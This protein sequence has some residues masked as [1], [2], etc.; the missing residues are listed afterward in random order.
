MTS[1]VKGS[2]S[3]HRQAGWTKRERSRFRILSATYDSVS[4]DSKT[5][6]LSVLA[7]HAGLGKATAYA[8]F[9]DPEEATYLL[10]QFG[11]LPLVSSPDGRQKHN[12]DWADLGDLTRVSEFVHTR[13]PGEVKPSSLIASLTRTIDRASRSGRHV[14]ET[15]SRIVLTEAL[16]EFDRG[17]EAIMQLAEA[18][19]SLE[20]YSSDTSLGAVAYI[21]LARSLGTFAA[22]YDVD[23]DEDPTRRFI[24]FLDQAAHWSAAVSRYDVTAIAAAEM[25]A[26]RW[27]F[28]SQPSD[29]ALDRS[30][31]RRHIQRA[32]VGES[33][34]PTGAHPLRLLVSLTKPTTVQQTRL[35]QF[36]VD[37]G[38]S[39][40]NRLLALECGSELPDS[41]KTDLLKAPNDSISVTCGRY[42]QTPRLSDRIRSHVREHGRAQAGE[43]VALEDLVSRIRVEIA[44]LQLGATLEPVEKNMLLEALLALTGLLE[45]GSISE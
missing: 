44:R 15:L 43:D 9:D 2:A 45:D 24:E 4:L 26:T 22:L 11:F 29:V 12:E 42:H 13:A 28:G 35:V 19:A 40:W 33:V 27:Y 18:Q 1:V 5:P 31:A 8:L 39:R 3:S 25:L 7:D 21:R 41:L 34:A 17:P 6:S 32:I 14:I 37:G 23:D 36:L 38:V 16:F 30:V 10:H 20:K